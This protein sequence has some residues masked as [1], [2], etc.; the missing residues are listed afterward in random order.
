MGS[1]SKAHGT[2]YEPPLAPNHPP[3]SKVSLI[4]T[5]HENLRVNSNI[6]TY[7]AKHS[8]D[9]AERSERDD[10]ECEASYIWRIRC[11]RGIRGSEEKPIFK[12]SY[13]I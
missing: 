8:V 4:S 6:I 5:N 1:H 3:S 10:W 11:T 2:P 9:Y 12:R 7:L 13:P